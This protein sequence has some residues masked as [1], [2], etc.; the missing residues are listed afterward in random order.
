MHEIMLLIVVV[1]LISLLYALKDNLIDAFIG[2]GLTL[3]ILYHVVP[4][5]VDRALG[6]TQKMRQIAAPLERLP[7]VAVDGTS[8]PNGSVRHNPE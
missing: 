8:A 1:T 3:F 6:I 7:L 4:G 2:I 5:Q